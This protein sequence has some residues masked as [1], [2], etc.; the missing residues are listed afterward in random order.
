[1]TASDILPASPARRRV[2]KAGAVTALAAA[3]GARTVFAQTARKI[4]FTLPWVAEGSNAFLWVALNKGYWKKLGLDVELARGSGSAM[5]AEAIGAGRFDFG[6][7]GTHI[8]ILQ[9]AKG[10][11]LKS[12]GVGSYDAAIGICT[13]ADSGIRAPK[14][15]EGKTLASTVSSTEYPF[16]PLFA[17]NGGLDLDKVKRVAV[18]AQLRQK[19]LLQKQVDAIS[20]A[21]GSMVPSMTAAGVKT[22]MMAFSQYGIQLYG[23]SIF[24]QPQ[25]FA[26]DPALCEA[27]VQGAMEGLA[28]TLTDPEGALRAFAAEVKEA[29]ISPG[30]L[31]QVKVG[32]GMFAS[33]AIQDDP[34]S[35]GLGWHNPKTIASMTDLTI[36]Y[37]AAPGTRKPD[38]ESLYTNQ[39][40]GRIKLSPAQWQAAKD[41]FKPYLAA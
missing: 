19:A 3:G 36:Q 40:A 16:I 21:I 26:S 6:Y 12:L 31:Q 7:C 20:G 39:F 27:V 5:A 8:G 14:D 2:L 22:N 33:S 4:K 9:T 37:V 41:Y 34:Q 29:A 11:P 38:P 17:K 28:Y 10:L 32:L 15:L 18:D 25:R 24:T 1:M 13:L 30:A 35:G 23:G